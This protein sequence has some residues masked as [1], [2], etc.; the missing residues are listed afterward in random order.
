MDTWRTP[1]ESDLG[2]RFYLKLYAQNECVLEAIA[3]FKC[4][5]NTFIVGVISVHS[6]NC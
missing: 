1:E 6:S 5:T 2:L 4:L 3:V